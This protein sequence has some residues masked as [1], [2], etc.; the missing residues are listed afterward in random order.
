MPF[1]ETNCAVLV[2]VTAGFITVLYAA[3]H[4]FSLQP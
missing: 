2:A 3:Y 4:F 1:I